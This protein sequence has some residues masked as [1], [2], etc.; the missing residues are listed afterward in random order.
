[1]MPVLKINQYNIHPE[2]SQSEKQTKKESCQ[3]LTTKN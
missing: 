1:M 3:Q 2:S